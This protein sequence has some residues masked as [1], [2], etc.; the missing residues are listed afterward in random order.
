MHELNKPLP[1]ILER[2]RDRIRPLQKLKSFT[3]SRI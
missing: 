2:Y 1:P 3:E